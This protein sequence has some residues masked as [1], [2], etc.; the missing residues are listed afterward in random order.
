MKAHYVSVWKLRGVA[1]LAP[2]ADPLKLSSLDDPL[3][4]AIITANP[5]SYL[6]EIDRSAAI[7]S[8]LFRGLFDPRGQGTTQERLAAE[9]E[10]TRAD[11][12]EQG[13]QEGVFLVIEG[14]TDIPA[15]AFETRRDTEEFAVC[16]DGFDKEMVYGRFRPFIKAV[17]TALGLSMRQEDDHR[18]ER[19]GHVTKLVD[20]ANGKPI[21][22]FT[23][24]GG[25]ATISMSSSFSDEMALDVEYYTPKILADQ[26][27]TRAISLLMASLDRNADQ[28]QAFV[29][30]WS[31]LEIFI[32]ATFKSAYE[33]RWFGVLEQVAPISAKPVFDRLQDV[34]KDKY[35]IADKFLIIASVLDPTSAAVDVT[36]FKDI[37]RVR[38]S[39]LH[40][41][42][43]PKQLPTNDIQ[44]FLLKY[45]RLHFDFHY[46]RVK[47]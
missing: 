29:G 23:L 31:A 24:E 47:V 4:D 37:K 14:E 35:R 30:A 7:V 28:F 21:Y 2:S 5:A 36:I 43:I 25:S 13:E 3:V 19:V 46:P 18:F 12:F 44:Q 8:L 42:E 20:P 34:M 22:P 16:L 26:S 6:F 15:P 41:L 17:Q 40:A 9:L 1:R 32:N 10:K 11:R 39:L 38:D 33:A 45:L 27:T